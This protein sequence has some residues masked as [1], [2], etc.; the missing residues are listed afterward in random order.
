MNSDH[1]QHGNSCERGV[2]VRV[3]DMPGPKGG[4]QACPNFE[5]EDVYLAV[6]LGNGTR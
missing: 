6:Y 1:I 5:R 4:V 3:G 2:F